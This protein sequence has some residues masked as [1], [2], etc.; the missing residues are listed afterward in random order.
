MNVTPNWAAAVILVPLGAAAVSMIIRSTG[1]RRLLWLVRA[2]AATACAVNLFVTIALF[3]HVVSDGGRRLVLQLGD[4]EAPF[5]IS[6]VVDGLAAALLLLTAILAAATIPFAIGTLDARERLHFHPLV[7]TLL[8]GVNGTFV[9]GDLFNLY[10]FFEILLMSSFVLLTL[11]GQRSQVNGGLRYVVL[12]LLASVVFLIT[13]G[14]AYGNLGTLN[15]AQLAERLDGAN[16]PE[17]EQ[18]LIALLLLI[19]FASKAGLFP[20]YFWLPSSYHTPAPAVTALFGGLLTK[21]GIYAL[22]RILSLLFPDLWVDWRRL[23]LI[24]AGATMV[25]GVL[26]AMAVPTIRRV[27]SFHVISQVGYMVMG[28]GLAATTDPAIAT[29]ALAAGIF[30]IGHHMIVKTALL[31]AGGVAELEAGGGNL[32]RGRLRGLVTTNRALAVLFFLAAFSLA[33]IPPSSGFV[34]K[35]GLLQAAIDDG[36]Y[37]IAAVSLVV[38]LL[39]MMSMVRLWQAAYWGTPST[40]ERPEERPLLRPSKR[41]LTLAPIAA[42]VVLSL[43]IGIFSRPVFEWSRVAAEQ[44]V[45]REGYIDAVSPS[46][47]VSVRTETAGAE[48]DSDG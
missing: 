22:F 41:L 11:G 9:A 17:A 12:N 45:D 27:L 16:V 24:V 37:T 42:L 36:R 39:T 35:L 8:T 47:D 48:A 33:G 6:L 5:G 20:F 21:V 1:S 2:I 14:V 31:M 4:W 40:E 46:D 10:V 13:A 38:S 34:A 44:A 18:R 30:Y 28:L 25:T 7:L 43:S 3:H 19:T 26:G 29:F 15:L 23:L 32:T